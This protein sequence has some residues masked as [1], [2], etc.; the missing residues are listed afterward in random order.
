MRSANVFLN[1]EEF[2]REKSRVA[3]AAARS[4]GLP[5]RPNVQADLLLTGR[6]VLDFCWFLHAGDLLPHDTVLHSLS[7]GLQK[8][9]RIDSTEEVHPESDGA[10]PTGLVTRAET[11]AVVAV[12]IF[13]EQDEVAPVRIVLKLCR[14]A[15]Y[16]PVAVCVAQEHLFES[17]LDLARHFEE[18]HSVTGTGRALYFEF[19]AVEAVQVQE[20]PHEQ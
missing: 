13:V 2:V 15:V 4:T 1:A 7:I 11:R 3:V 14:S 8:R 5:Q 12:E 9:L 18:S 20:A 17:P 10:G 6:R 19:V 16:R